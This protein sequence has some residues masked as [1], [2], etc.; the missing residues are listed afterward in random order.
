[1][2][3]MRA[4]QRY[5]ALEART[6]RPPELRDDPERP[7]RGHDEIRRGTQAVLRARLEDARFYWETT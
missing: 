4:H 5:F 3:A 1:M 6:A 7:R 2:T